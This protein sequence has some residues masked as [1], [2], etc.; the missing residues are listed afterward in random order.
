MDYRRSNDNGAKGAETRV[1]S[2]PYFYERGSS[3]DS[4]C[5]AYNL[6]RLRRNALVTTDTELSAMAAPANTGDSSKPKAG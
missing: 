3:A 6:T 5:M 4:A 2:E 1:S